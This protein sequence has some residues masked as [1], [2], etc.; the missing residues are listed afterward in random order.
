VGFGLNGLAL[1][2]SFTRGAWIGAV[3]SIVLLG[4]MAWRQRITL[5][6]IDWI[7]AGVCGLAGIGLLVR[8]LSSAAA[9][10]NFIERLS[11]IFQFSSGSGQTRTE[12]WRAAGAAIKD[13]PLFGWGADNFTFAFSR[14]KPVEYLRDAGASSGADNAHN[15][16][17]HLASGVGIL[18]AVLF[19]AILGWAGVRSFRTVFGRSGESGR[20]IIGAFWAASAGYLVHLLSGI[21]V[22]GITFLLW[23]TLALV[24]APS[25]RTIEVKA[26][27]W[28]TVVAAT[29]ILVTCAAIAGQ[30]IALAADGAY[31]DSKD[32]FS[33]TLAQREAAA[34]RALELDPYNPDYRTAL[35]SARFDQVATDVGAVLWA[36]EHGEDPIP[37]VDALKQSFA[38]SESAYE[39]AIEFTPYEYA[40]YVNL[41]SLYNSAAPV[42]GEDLFQSALG[43]VARGL[44]VM[45]LGTAIRVQLAKALLGTGRE[46]EAVETLEYCLQLDQRDGSAALALAGIYHEQCRTAE[47]LTLLRSVEALAPGQAGVAGTIE[48]LEAESPPD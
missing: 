3:L 4:I 5:R 22:P 20:M 16:P 35:A 45:P 41:A 30:A 15:Y 47:A 26:F 28:G 42:L 8:S 23:I 9:E 25:A 29:I 2:V 38:E 46:A 31:L 10:T 11:S 43:V 7:P 36:R 44:E 27:R 40:N 1:I 19:Y 33:R 14:F 37:Y 48:A 18:G 12:I 32:V 17:L 39:D 13:R 24:L 6:R 21:S 34:L